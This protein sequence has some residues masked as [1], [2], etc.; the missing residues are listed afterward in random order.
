[1]GASVNVRALPVL[2]GEGMDGPARG[3][4]GG[5]EHLDTVGASARVDLRNIAL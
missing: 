2:P 4:S 3:A 1:M 5:L